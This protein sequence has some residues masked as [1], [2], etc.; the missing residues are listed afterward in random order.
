MYCR[1]LLKKSGSRI[2]RIEL[3][4][5]GPSIDFK[6]RRTKISS[7]DLFKLACK[8][9]KELKASIFQMGRSYPLIL[10]NYKYQLPVINLLSKN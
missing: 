5:I 7:D 2:P 3:E 4:E 6:L 10:C 8:R 9:P 1:I